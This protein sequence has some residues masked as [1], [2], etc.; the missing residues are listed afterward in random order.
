MFIID[1]GCVPEPD[2]T[3]HGV[4]SIGYVYGFAAILFFV[5]PLNGFDR[6]DN[7]FGSDVEIQ[8]DRLFSCSIVTNYLLENV[9][10]RAGHHPIFR[11]RKSAHAWDDRLDHRQAVLRQIDPDVRFDEPHAVVVQFRSGADTNAIVARQ[12]CNVHSGRADRQ[13]EP[14]T[15]RCVRQNHQQAV[16]Q[17]HCRR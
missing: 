3:S 13:A 9:D 10:K 4:K 5:P 1:E 6:V 12:V 2:R 15:P 16:R 8:L 11:H 17:G 7:W 14:R